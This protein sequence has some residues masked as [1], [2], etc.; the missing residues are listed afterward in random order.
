[1]EQEKLLSAIESIL[2]ISGEP[3]KK[4]KL[5]KIFSGQAKT[6]DVEKGI[7]ALSEKYAGSASGLVLL[8]KGEEVQLAS[9][10]ENSQYVEKMVKS[11]LQ[12]SLSNAAMEVV[13]IIAYRGPIS[14]TE[15]ESIR[16]VNCSYTLRNLLL[17][18]LIERSDN[19]RDGRGYVYSITFEFLKKLGVEDVKK[20]PDHDILSK[21]ERINSIT[22]VDLE[23]AE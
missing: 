22:N 8:R 6:E 5:V 18:G 3:I 14:K 1:M 2:F 19:P 15:I 13:S 11:E 16:G 23:V 4:S 20:L 21:D 7:D 12:D 17:R 10:A 9:K